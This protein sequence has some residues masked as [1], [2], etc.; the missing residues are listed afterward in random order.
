MDGH[1]PP[2]QTVKEVEAL[3]HRTREEAKIVEQ[4]TAYLERGLSAI[5]VKLDLL[6]GIEMENTGLLAALTKKG[7]GGNGVNRKLVGLVG[8]AITVL[9]VVIYSL[10]S[11]DVKAMNADTMSR[12]A[13][14]QLSISRLNREDR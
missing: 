10:I 5:G 8:T 1:T 3:L 2:C 7:N 14:I 6:Q 11:R 13:E 4:K 12:I 9:G